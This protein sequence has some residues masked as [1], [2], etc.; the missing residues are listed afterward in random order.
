MVHWLPKAV[1]ISMDIV[2]HNIVIVILRTWNAQPMLLERVIKRSL[3][4]DLVALKQDLFEGIGEGHTPEPLVVDDN[5]RGRSHGVNA[6]ELLE[7]HIVNAHLP[8][9]IAY[10]TIHRLPV[11]SDD[12]D[13]SDGRLLLE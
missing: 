1:E 4:L 9:L 12:F 6:E 3:C 8:N 13:S 7:V 10:H 5:G 11:L 2:H